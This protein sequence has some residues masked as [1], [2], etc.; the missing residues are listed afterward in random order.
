MNNTDTLINAFIETLI[1]R[2][3][4]QMCLSFKMSCNYYGKEDFS[5]TRFIKVLVDARRRYIGIYINVSDKAKRVTEI[6]DWTNTSY[7]DSCWR[8]DGMRWIFQNFIE[9]RNELGDFLDGEKI[10]MDINEVNDK[11]ELN[12]DVFY[13]FEEIEFETERDDNDRLSVK[14][15]RAI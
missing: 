9:M 14:N 13:F 8:T 15:I 12:P 4:K 3:V 10:Q 1:E 5:K 7:H 2:E 11:V 6:K